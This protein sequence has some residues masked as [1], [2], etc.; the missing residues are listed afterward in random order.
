MSFDLI[1]DYQ[2]L[3]NRLL[4]SEFHSEALSLSGKTLDDYVL[5]GFYGCMEDPCPIVDVFTDDDDRP[6]FT[7]DEADA[8]FAYLRN[9]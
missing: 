4:T 5:Q 7:E 1:M 8:L 2:S 3:L 9:T 6:F